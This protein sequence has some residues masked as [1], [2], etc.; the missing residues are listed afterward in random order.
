[1]L[2]CYCVLSQAGQCAIKDA[3]WTEI[4]HQLIVACVNLRDK[5]YTGVMCTCDFSLSITILSCTNG[6]N[7]LV[8][9]D[10]NVYVL[11]T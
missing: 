1:M 11:F 8:T 10:K 9:V 5:V 2:S 7:I 3:V 4:L 6:T